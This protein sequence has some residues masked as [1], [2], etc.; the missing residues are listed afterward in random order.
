MGKK[1]RTA[2][3]RQENETVSGKKSTEKLQQIYLVSVDCAILHS[4]HQ[5]SKMIPV[6]SFEC[7]VFLLVQLPE[8]FQGMHTE[9]KEIAFVGQDYSCYVSCNIKFSLYN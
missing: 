5:F 1:K 4:C 2:Y 7:I 3:E 6:V 8:L 9:A